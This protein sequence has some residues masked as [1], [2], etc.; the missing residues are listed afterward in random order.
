MSDEVE[1]TFAATLAD[2]GVRL[3][4][5]AVGVRMLVMTSDQRKALVSS[6]GLNKVVWHKEREKSGRFQV[7][8][9]D[10]IV[11][12]I[13]GDY[14][15]LIQRIKLTPET[16]RR[17]GGGNYAYRNAYYTLATKSRRPTWGQYNA[18]IPERWYRKLVSKAIAKGWVGLVVRR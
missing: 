13:V 17:W 2:H 12:V 18:L 8:V 7:G 15:F 4:K 16:A 6:T 9:I 11:S 14:N 10:D 5:P 3:H 1:P